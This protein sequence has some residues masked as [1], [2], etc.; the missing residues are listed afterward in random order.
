MPGR[1][2][3]RNSKKGVT[4]VEAI[5]AAAIMVIMVAGIIAIIGFANSLISKNK[6]QDDGFATA[7][8]IADAVMTAISNGNTD[9]DDLE[10]LTGAEHVRDNSDFSS[11]PN[12]KEFKFIYGTDAKGISGYKIY[13]RVN[14]SEGNQLAYITA[15]AA[16]KGGTTA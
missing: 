1:L 3:M 14:D 9:P 6:V 15:F 5:V 10:A 2:K 11:D 4:L 13:V 16:V 8:G 7:E 12:A